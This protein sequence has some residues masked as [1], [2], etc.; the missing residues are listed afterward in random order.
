MHSTSDPVPRSGRDPSGAGA[1]AERASEAELFGEDLLSSWVAI[2][3]RRGHEPAR[4]LALAE[5]RVLARLGAPLS[6]MRALRR[7]GPAGALSPKDRRERLGL[8]ASLHKGL[9]LRRGEPS[10]RDRHERRAIAL[11]RRAFRADGDPWPLVNVASMHRLR[12]EASLAE[13]AALRTLSILDAP[14]PEDG[15]RAATRGEALLVL[16]R[17]DEAARAYRDAPFSTARRFADAAS[18]R[19]QARRILAAL[20]LDAPAVEA[21][22]ASTLPRPRIGVA[23]GHML[24]RPERPTPRFAASA[25]GAVGEAL[26]RWVRERG[27][28]FGLASA[29]AGTD[30]LFHEAV[31]ATGA[32]SRIVLPFPSEVFRTT[33]VGPLGPDWERRYEALLAAG[34]EWV[35]V[36]STQPLGTNSAWYE[37]GNEVLEGMALCKADEIDGEIHR[38]AVWDGRPGDGPGG[39]AATVRRWVARCAPFDVIDPRADAPVATTWSRAPSAA[40]VGEDR[41]PDVLGIL[42][43][44][45]RGYG[46]L[47]DDG[48]A[49]FAAH[50]LPEIAAAVGADARGGRTEPLLVKTWGDGL[51]AAH[52]DLE[53]IAGLAFELRNRVA[54]RRWDLVGLPRTLTLRIALHAGPVKRIRNAVT[55][56]DDLL[57]SHVSHAARLEPVT[58]PG[59]IFASEGFAALQRLRCPSAARCVLV[60]HGAWAKGFGAG[61]GGL[62]MYRVDEG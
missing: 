13:E 38:V 7:T 60:G 21:W 20:R 19:R 4:A 50:V 61:V 6:A 5:G 32:R 37:Y 49:R 41:A 33:S 16:G 24:D 34:A 15:W 27:I 10:L 17:L 28:D 1:R 31:R 45:A 56:R 12:G 62:P 48:L 44:D 46:D 23:T 42:T 47:D 8:R 58:P 53:R 40:S 57:G 29:A 51:L 18:A 52:P 11:Y 25:A 54:R 14:G 59:E 22:I 26:A 9:A 39:T 2:A 30:V 55:G 35:S 43:A 3:G 36:A